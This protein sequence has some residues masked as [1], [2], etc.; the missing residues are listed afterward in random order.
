MS[1]E[2]NRRT[3]DVATLLTRKTVYPGKTVRLEV[4]RVALPGGHVCELEIIHHPG[5]SCIVP[6]L[7]GTDGEEEIV[8]IRQ[9]RHAAGGFILE[10]PAGKLEPGE[11]PAT[12]AARELEEETGWRPGRLESLGSILTTPGFTDERIHLYV[13]HDLLPGTQATEESEV[14]TV[15]RVPFDEAQA[16]CRDGRIQD[17]KTICGL[18]LADAHRP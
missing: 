15:L 14:L 10:L 7:S 8:L 6:F 12:C 9:Y 18:A 5:A 4:E 16:M 1:D 3:Q 13:A 2:T 17:A 11:D